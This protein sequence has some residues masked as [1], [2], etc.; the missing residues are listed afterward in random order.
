MAGAAA[1]CVV[2][3]GNYSSTDKHVVKKGYDRNAT[4]M[5]AVCSSIAR[6]PTLNAVANYKRLG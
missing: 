1:K 5:M 6:C 3:I 2:G 4:R